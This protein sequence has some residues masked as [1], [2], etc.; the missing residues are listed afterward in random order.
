M[1][2]IVIGATF[3]LLFCL[4]AWHKVAA[5][6]GRTDGSGGHTCRTNC[7]SW[8]LDYGDYHYHGGYDSSYDDEDE[9]PHYA[10]PLAT[11]WV[12]KIG[13]KKYY[14]MSSAQ[15]DWYGEIHKSVDEVYRVLLERKTNQTDYDHWDKQFPF[16]NCSGGSWHSQK[17]WDEVLA[18]EERKQ[19]LEK[20][21]VAG[22]TETPTQDTST[23]SD[24]GIGWWSLWWLALFPISWIFDWYQKRS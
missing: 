10:P 18:S 13:D 12:C 17:I 9:S 19:L 4:L 7:P 23:T 22:V 15:A 14:S 3:S 8:G 24:P 5:H 2:S 6:P 1:S 16:N 21:R 20:K 11:T